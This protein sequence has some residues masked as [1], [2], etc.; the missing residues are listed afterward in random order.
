MIRSFADKETEKVF[1]GVY[2]RSLPKEIQK[3]ALARLVAL[4]QAFDLQD[5]RLPPS[6]RLEA[7]RGD[8]AGFYSLRINDQW[9]IVFRWEGGTA[10]E[11]GIADYH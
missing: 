11:V 9:R 2:S 8:L 1:R 7:L 4:D 5:L 3:R 10:L 6:N